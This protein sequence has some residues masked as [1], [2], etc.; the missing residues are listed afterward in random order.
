[1]GS[2]AAGY[3]SGGKIEYGLVPLGAVG[4]TVF[5][6]T[7][8]APGLTYREALVHLAL[9]G[10]FGGFFIVPIAAIMQHRPARGQKGAVLAAGNL[11]SFVGIALAS[12]Y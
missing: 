4:L 11:L 1:M 5:S 2:F 12:G 7:L 6:A 9:L 10:F 3:L 8:W